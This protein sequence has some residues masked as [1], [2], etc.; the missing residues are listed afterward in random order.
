M[1]LYRVHGGSK[2]GNNLEMIKVSI[3]NREEKIM[4]R[5]LKEVSQRGCEICI[6]GSLQGLG[7]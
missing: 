2:R 7:G 6:L 4:M 1:V 5:V 3:G